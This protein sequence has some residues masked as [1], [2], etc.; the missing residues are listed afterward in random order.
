VEAEPKTASVEPSFPARLGLLLVHPARALAGIVER[1]GGS[2]RDGLI[3]VL[4]ASVTYRLPELIRAGRSF[5]RVSGAV[6]LTQLVGVFASELRTA[7]TVALASALAVTILAGR[8]RRDP[9]L[10]LELG[11]ACY[12]PYFVTWAPIRLL[13]LDAWLGNVPVPVAA[14]TRVVAWSWVVA[15]V[16]ISVRTVR[17]STPVS[18]SSPR[19]G[20]YAGLALLALP[21]A[22]LVT[23]AVWS[24][25]NYDLLRPLG[26]DDH[27]PDFALPRVDGKPG[28]IRLGD[29]RGKVVLLD[30]WATWCPPCLAMMPTLHELYR[31]WQPRGA[32]FVAINSDLPSA[33]PEDVRE[34]VAHRAFPY[35]V[36]LDDRNVGASYGVSSIPHLA[37]VGRD[38]KIARIFVGAVGRE[39][40]ERALAAAS[41]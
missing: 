12:V 29:L 30:F 28:Q 26:R 22:G 27:A 11:A 41:E 16:A 17:R 6:A 37:I 15:L 14:V 34:F 38:G 33:T 18:P 19:L 39:Q 9:S 1:K 20:L 35:P 4:I 10:G 40:L 5:S 7:A 36:V 31:E 13:D 23:N 24:A 3:L 8:G 32:E 25:R 21:V 2:L